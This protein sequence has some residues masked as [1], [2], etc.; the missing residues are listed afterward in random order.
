[1]AGNDPVLHAIVIACDEQ[2]VGATSNSG[3]RIVRN[4]IQHVNFAGDQSRGRGIALNPDLLHV[5]TFAL[6]IAGILGH[7]QRQNATADIAIADP[8]FVGAKGVVWLNQ[9]PAE[10]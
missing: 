3:D 6:V 7:P 8:K 1:M 9:Q 2:Q 5:E 10:Y 4:A